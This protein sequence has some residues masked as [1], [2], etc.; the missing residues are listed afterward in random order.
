MAT[1][2]SMR[3]GLADA[4]RRAA[5]DAGTP[6]I[7]ARDHAPNNAHDMLRAYYETGRIIVWSG[8]SDRTIWGPDKLNWLFRG[9]HDW[10]HI[11]HGA[12]RHADCFLPSYEREIADFQS[13][14]I[15]DALGKLVRIEIADQ[16]THY[17]RTGSFVEDQIAFTL[18]RLDIR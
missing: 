1:I 12:C 7:E 17:E 15:P 10:E 11:L 16:A 8:G 5:K 2:H 4:L 3:N 13:R 18:D 14:R 9:W 6:S